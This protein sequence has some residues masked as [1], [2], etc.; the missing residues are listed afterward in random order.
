MQGRAATRESSVNLDVITTKPKLY[1]VQGS[2]YSYALP[3]AYL[4]WFLSFSVPDATG[5]ALRNS[6]DGGVV[7]LCR[8]TS[9]C[10]QTT[11]TTMQ[12]SGELS[13]RPGETWG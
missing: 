2:S 1:C 4:R 5:L 3:S 8:Y 12:Q 6:R 11:L 13:V 10:A 9:T 7:H